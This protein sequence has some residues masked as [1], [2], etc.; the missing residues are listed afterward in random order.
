[1]TGEKR[2][3]HRLDF[4]IAG[5]FG[6]RSAA[7]VAIRAGRVLLS[8]RPVTRCGIFLSEEDLEEISILPE[9][10]REVGEKLPLPPILFENAD[11]LIFAKPAGMLTVPAGKPRGD[12]L[13]ERLAAAFPPSSFAPQPAHRLDRDTSGVLLAA[14]T[15]DALR[16]FQEEFAERRVEKTYL[17]LVLDLE[18]KL[19]ASGTI[20][21]PLSSS[22]GNA[23]VQKV[24]AT[25]K[26]RPARTHFRALERK[27]IAGVPTALVEID[28]ETGRTHQIRAHFA[29]IGF[30]VVGDPVYGDLE[31]NKIFEREFEL[32]RQ[33]L[34]ARR[35]AIAFPDGERREFSAELPEE[36]A[37]F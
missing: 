4:L 7:Q 21:S 22:R 28:L 35:L 16:F 12:S 11:A 5:K 1:M 29:A 27:E 36:L 31:R 26:A 15:P 19:P 6:T 8:G 3:R 34:H 25:P 9:P 10:P 30:P 24:S 20:D 2:Q 37:R 32:R 17:A 13:S 14:K 23:L 33:W 18:K